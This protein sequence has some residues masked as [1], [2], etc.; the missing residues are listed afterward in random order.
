[1]NKAT[2]ETCRKYF[3][4]VL[5]A[6][7]V[8][9]VVLYS[10]VLK[11][12][13][14]DYVYY[15]ARLVVL[16]IVGQ[17]VS[18]LSVLGLPVLILRKFSFVVDLLLMHAFVIGW[19]VSTYL[20]LKFR[21]KGDDKPLYDCSISSGTS[22]CVAMSIILALCITLLVAGILYIL[23]IYVYLW[24][25]RSKSSSYNRWANYV[26]GLWVERPDAQTVPAWMAS[27]PSPQQ[28]ANHAVWMPPSP[29]HKVPNLSPINHHHQSTS[30]SP[31][32][33][34]V[35]VVVVQVPSN[36]TASSNNQEIAYQTLPP[37]ICE[38][39]CH[40]VFLHKLSAEADS[41]DGPFAGAIMV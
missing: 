35:Q 27:Q 3:F 29:A 38:C 39:G 4:G 14:D 19:M 7:S 10:R 23:A 9:E 32:A 5:L 37:T 11:A 21:S 24:T 20:M 26:S 33:P 30:T 18:A 6:L 41:T 28:D 40:S 16:L 34:H 2:V 12:K 22:Y 31:P 15:R 36:P 25:R 8:I 13:Y 17:A 1:M